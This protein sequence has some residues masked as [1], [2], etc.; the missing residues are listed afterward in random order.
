MEKNIKHWFLGVILSL[1]SLSSIA[2]TP[3]LEVYQPDS[4]SNTSAILI[5]KVKRASNGS[6][7]LSRGFALKTANAETYN[8]NT[9]TSFD[10]I[11]SFNAI[12]LEINTRYQVAV[13]ALTIDSFYIS[14]TIGFNTLNPTIIPQILSSETTNITNT[15]AI[16]NGNLINYG[17]P[18]INAKG[19][20][21]STMS[22][23]DYSNAQEIIPISGVDI[24]DFSYQKT[25]LTTGTNYYYRTY[26]TNSD[27]VILGDIISFMTTSSS[28]VAPQLSTF[29]PTIIDENTA[30]FFGAILMVGS[31]TITGIGFDWRK[32]TETTFTS[33]IISPITDTF[34][35]TLTNLDPAT[36]YIVRAF[37][38]TA[39][40]KTFG[41]TKN[42]ITPNI[43]DIYE[44]LNPTNISSNSATLN[45]YLANISTPIQSFG[46][47]LKEGDGNYTLYDISPNYNPPCSLS[48]NITN[49]T[50]YQNY[51][52][53]VY[54]LG[55]SD[56]YYGD[57]I[58]FNTNSIPAIV[59][60]NPATNLTYNTAQLNGRLSNAG[61]P[62][63]IEKGFIYSNQ[64]ILEF[65]NSTKII[66]DGT[67]IEP[68]SYSLTGINQNTIFYYRSY[69]IS[70]I[71]TSYGA[72]ISFKT[73]VQGITPPTLTTL[74]ATNITYNSAILNGIENGGNE[75]IITRGFQYKAEND[76]NYTSINIDEGN[77][78]QTSLT[79]LLPNTRYA[80]R[81]FASTDLTTYYGNELEFSTPETPMII[82]TNQPS[83]ITINSATLNG[84]IYDGNEIV[85]FRGIEWKL[86]SDTVYHREFI[87]DAEAGD[88]SLDIENLSPFT[89][90][91]YKIF[92]RTEAQFLYG[93]N[94]SFFT[95]EI[96]NPIVSNIII[97]NIDTNSAHL[98]G[99]IT[100]GNTP[101][102]K[103]WFLI[104]KWGQDEF[105]SHTLT[106]NLLDIII[107]TLEEGTTYYV[108]LY[109][110]TS[111]GIIKN[112]TTSFV[113]LG[114]HNIGLNNIENQDS[115]I[116]IYPN[117]SSDIINIKINN[118][119]TNGNTFIIISDIK[120]RIIDKKQIYTTSITYDISEFSKGIYTISLIS[121]DGKHTRKL[122][123][124]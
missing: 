118:L 106:N 73:L 9:I 97:D 78:I 74:D 19:F 122:I 37:A 98:Y 96:I 113:T 75:N 87:L 64:S 38:I 101:I 102:I 27:T 72:I 1:I 33:N 124:K 22:N 49:I 52:Y 59:K 107:D 80:F 123:V 40:G 60:T 116:S 77:T 55:F 8:Y 119:N 120:G 91:T 54:A 18:I 83:S 85:L 14:D 61:T 30:S 79:N 57:E 32:I 26:A 67:N 43:S 66:I 36:T 12:D 29:T 50:P 63:I 82:T 92:A 110:L 47:A 23:F 88:I 31:E 48:H 11:I 81:V 2:Q 76:I 90:Y 20:L 117:P 114:T 21:F 44:T 16:L 35:L 58:T 4:I 111:Y 51:T 24:G 53:K 25:G 45:G 13:I 10:S 93:E 94:I 42:F 112:E 89:E 6:L 28:F 56:I 108:A 68:Y 70:P 84:N 7:L 41:E 62:I 95:N 34:N 5:G 71:D 15:G 3:I 17:N 121:N 46:F 86:T 99:T 65:S 105:V 39:S 100:M 104:S 109:A 69:S 103:T 115:F